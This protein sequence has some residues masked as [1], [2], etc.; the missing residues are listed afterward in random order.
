MKYG[1]AFIIGVGVTAILSPNNALANNVYGV[2]KDVLYSKSKL[3]AIGDVQEFCVSLNQ[4]GMSAIFLRKLGGNGSLKEMGTLATYNNEKNTLYTYDHD[5]R[6]VKKATNIVEPV[7]VVC[8][9]DES[10][11]KMSENA[12]AFARKID[13]DFIEYVKHRE[14]LWTN[15]AE[16]DYQVGERVCSYDNKLGYIENTAENN[17]KVLWKGRVLN[18]D[19][20]YFFGK[21]DQFSYKDDKFEYDQLDDIRWEP[22]EQIGKC[23][24][25][26][27]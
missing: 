21:R 19:K 4:K 27:L 26:L 8:N 14:L 7:T 17:H 24:F 11:V 10:T 2:S 23:E 25:E 6:R 3:N 5:K 22:K 12:K 20:G 9:Y 18:K 15:R 13:V 16:A 1:V